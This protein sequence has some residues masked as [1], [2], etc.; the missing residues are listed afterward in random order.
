MSIASDLQRL[1]LAKQDLIDLLT[2]RGVTLPANVK[3]EDMPPLI[4][5]MIRIERPYYIN[6]E[7]G[8]VNSNTSYGGTATWTYQLPQ[9]SM[10]DVYKLKSGH[11]YLAFAGGP[12]GTRF[13]VMTTTTDPVG[14]TRNITGTSLCRRDNPAAGFTWTTNETPNRIYTAPSDCFLLIQKDNTYND[15]IRTYVIDATYLDNPGSPTWVE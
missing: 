4:A 14:A 5:G 10:T 9:G 15:A 2:F 6:L 7:T 1:A 3:T 8:W 13:R 12:A 11:K